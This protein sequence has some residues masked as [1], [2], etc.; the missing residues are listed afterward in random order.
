MK[1]YEFVMIML[2]GYG[3]RY[4]KTFEMINSVINNKQ[5]DMLNFG[6][7][8]SKVMEAL[9]ALEIKVRYD[10]LACLT[11]QLRCTKESFELDGHKFETL[12]EVEKALEN[13]AFL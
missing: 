13:K 8:K 10:S 3:S 11:K 9:Q 2:E 6:T 7:V 5:C 12:D 1:E 4:Y